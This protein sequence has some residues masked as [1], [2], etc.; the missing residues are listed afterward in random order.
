[1][2]GDEGGAVN[3]T[4]TTHMLFSLNITPFIS[5]HSVAGPRSSLF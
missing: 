4:D 3:K 5:S 2:L 1:M